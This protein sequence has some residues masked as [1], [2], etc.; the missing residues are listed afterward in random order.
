MVPEG[1]IESRL[2][3]VATLQRGFDLPQQDRV[4]GPYPIIS[5]GGTTGYHK[6]A[7]ASGPG[8]VT[9]RY[10]SIGEI[11]Y[12]TEDYW[13]LNTSL[14]VK[15]FHG[16]NRKFI[17]YLLWTVDF[18]KLSDKTG[19]P[20]VNRNDAHRLRVYLPPLPEQQK[21]AQI[22]STWDR[23]ID[24]LEAL[25]AAK[26]KRKTALMQMLLTGKRRL[27]GFSGA[28]KEMRLRDLARE[29]KTRNPNKLGKE[30]VRAV[31]KTLGM[32]PMKDRTI[33]N[34]LDRYKT[35]EKN[36]FAYNPMRINVGSI[37]MWDK[38]D[39]VLVSPDY[40]VF[41][42]RPNILVPQFLHYVRMTHR[43]DQYVQFSGNGS[44]RVRIYFND[45][46]N[47][48]FQVPPYE[49]QQK[50]AAVLSAAD[51]E[52]DTHQRQLDALKTK[53]KGLMQ[54]LLTGKKRVVIDEPDLTAAVEG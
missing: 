44:V 9:G 14:W 26:Q 45:L 12:I 6:K 27:P 23:A 32:I 20:G 11:F 42:C 47:F 5:S 29:S 48:R 36:W 21:I 53:K 35:V 38:K 13:P 50:I 8:V 4:D 37:C 51:R 10:G 34:D 28:W 1:W 49:E 25:I 2:G 19:I 41:F 7:M 54:Q 39:P 3:S 17:Y 40:V 30:Y 24:T 15:D 33:S 22:L 18:K 43:W 46:G 16:N 52:I 31:N